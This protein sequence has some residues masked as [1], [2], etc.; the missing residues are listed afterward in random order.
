MGIDWY[1]CDPYSSWQRRQNER[2]NRDVRRFLPKGTDFS[3][4]TPKEFLRALVDINNRSRPKFN[5]LSANQMELF[6]K[7]FK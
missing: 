6:Y 7:K 5:L 3:K 2:L 1:F 4:V